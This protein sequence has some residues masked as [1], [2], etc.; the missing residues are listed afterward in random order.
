MEKQKAVSIARN[1]KA[2][3]VMSGEEIAEVSGLTKEEISKL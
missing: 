1:L 3:G 2:K